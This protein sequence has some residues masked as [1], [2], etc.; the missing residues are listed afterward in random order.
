[1]LL[2]LWFGHIS[3]VGDK[4][5]LVF[6]PSLIARLAIGFVAF[7]VSPLAFL[8][9][10]GVYNLVS[11]LS[12][13]AYSGLMRSNY[14]DK[15]RG[16]AMGSIRILIQVVSAV[17]AALAGW[18]FEVLPS[19]YRLLFPA[20]AAFGIL[21]CFEFARI[22]ERK[23]LRPGMEASARTS[24]ADAVSLIAR[25]R[26]FLVYQAIFFIMG[27]PDKIMIPLEP[28]RLVDELGMN[29]AIAGIVQGTIPLLSSIVGYYVFGRLL[30]R[31]DPF[32]LLVASVT[33]AAARFLNIAVA[34]NPLDLIPGAFINGIANAGWDLLPLFTLSRFAGSGD[35][36]LFMG[37]HNMLIGV[38][39]LIGPIFGV[40]LNSALGMRIVDVY[41]I[42]FA[43]QVFSACLLLA[44]ALRLRGKA[45][46]ERS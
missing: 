30:N 11:A 18:C 31:A 6:W 21:S 22:R 45:V 38:R 37:F 8:A 15:H 33:C 19:G 24:F 5:L 4:R 7:A 44:F 29:Y 23:W 28:I 35:F 32:L 26:E 34:V 40:W 1:M 13:P 14:S 25:N 9:C 39:G 12:G 42:A 3:D 46:T 27:F 16:E 17:F 2:N 20:A 43:I 36:A 10:A 41:W